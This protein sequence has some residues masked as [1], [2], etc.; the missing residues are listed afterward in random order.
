LY[1]SDRDFLYRPLLPSIKNYTT[2]AGKTVYLYSIEQY[3]IVNYRLEAYATN[4]GFY[5]IEYYRLEAYATNLGLCWIEYYRLE[6]Y[7]TNLG[8]N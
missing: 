3:L 1:F 6:A 8:Y 4:L 5:L 2:S 7:A